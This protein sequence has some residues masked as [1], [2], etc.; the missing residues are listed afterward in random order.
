IVPDI[1]CLGK[2]ISSSLPVSA[3][4]GK[5]EIMNQYGPGSMTSTHSG[6][7]LGCAASLASIDLIEREGLV[8][9]ARIVGER[10]YNGLKTITDKHSE[11]FDLQGRG[12]V[13]ALMILR[14][15]TDYEPDADMAFEI[16]LRCFEAGLLMFAPVG[17]GGGCVKISP[18]LCISGDAVDEGVEVLRTVVDEVIENRR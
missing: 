1:I 8:Q 6:H 18:P 5:E 9:N 13:Y 4:V 7:P 11:L 15:R 10:L 3:V 17:R 12:L 2:G 14:N 16:I